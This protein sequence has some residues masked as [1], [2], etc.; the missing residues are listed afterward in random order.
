M[1]PKLKVLNKEIL[2]ILKDAQATSTSRQDEI[3]KRKIIIFLFMQIRRWIQEF[4]K[5]TINSNPEIYYKNRF[6]IVE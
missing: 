3:N 6:E 1:H 2:K 4:L 5:E